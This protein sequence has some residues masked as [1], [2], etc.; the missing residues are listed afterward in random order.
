MFELPAR[1]GQWPL[2]AIATLIAALAFG[3]QPVS[4]RSAARSNPAQVLR[5][6]NAVRAQHGA[7]PLRIDRRLARA[8]RLHSRDM[9][10]HRY[11][12]HESLSGDRP[13]ARVARTGWMAGRR[14]WHVGED[15][16]WGIGPNA[17]PAAIVAA[18][19]RSPAHRRVLLDR[20]YRVVGVGIA[21]GTPVAGVVRGLTYTA[22]FGT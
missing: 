2:L 22:D 10:A 3:V 7:S 8:A 9:V 12:A 21:L 18:W 4:A 13:S 6:I 14:A 15:L 1:R 16:A 17:R 19:L 5:L 11:F 20:R